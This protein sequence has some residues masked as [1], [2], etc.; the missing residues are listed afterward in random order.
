MSN[1]KEVFIGFSSSLDLGERRGEGRGCEVL[2][3]T[4]SVS[5]LLTGFGR[6]ERTM[7]KVEV[8]FHC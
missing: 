8:N 4:R 3:V 2:S 5:G 6:A 7:G 1:R